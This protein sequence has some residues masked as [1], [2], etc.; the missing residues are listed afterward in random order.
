MERKEDIEYLEKFRDVVDQYL[1]LGYAPSVR[2]TRRRHTV[3]LSRLN[4]PEYQELRRTIN[5]MKPIVQQLMIECGIF[6][7][8]TEYP[9]PAVGGLVVQVPMLDLITQNPLSFGVPKG[10]FF[11]YI[12]QAIGILKTNPPKKSDPKLPRLSVDLREGYVFIA[13]PMSSDDDPM[14]DDVHEAI[15]EIATEVNCIAE[16]VD[17]P[18]SS[19]RITDRILQSIESAEYVVADLTHAKPNVYFEAGYAHGLGKIPIYIARE[20]TK[21]EF[22]LKDY[23]VIFFKNI[24]E[25]KQRLHERLS[26]LKQQRQ[27]T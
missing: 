11:D 4:K 7:V 6:P 9:A 22:D 17:D 3:D 13:M 16:R 23:P 5:E 8:M 1:F 24:K 10:Q 20:D 14:L 15:K 25:L 26:G 12:D 27:S 2:Y 19:D 21:I 18:V